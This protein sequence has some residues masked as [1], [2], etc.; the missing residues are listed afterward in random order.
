[1]AFVHL[2]VHT[3]YSIL[4]G[5]SSISTLF[6][7]AEEMGMPALAITDHGNMYGVKEFF[8]FAGK[9]VDKATGHF[10]VKPIIG[11]EVYVTRHYDPKLKDSE[12]RSYYHLILL[13]K[14][15]DGYKNLMKI[16]SQGHIEGLYYGKPRVSHEIIEK[17]HENLICCSACLAGEIPKNIVSGKMDEARKAIEWHKRVFGDDYYLE[18]MLH[19]TEV[20]G[21]SRDVY[22][23]QKISNEGIFQLA[24]EMGVK[25][26]ATND[27]HFVN[28]EDGPAHD[29]L[30]CLNTGKKINEEPR[31]H[32]TQQEYLKSE[33]EMAALFPDHPEVLENTLEI[34]SKV[35]EYQI[36]RDHVL[37]KY[38][39]DQ[40]FLDDLDNYLNM[41]KD[42]IEVGKCDKKGNYRGDEFC[43]SVAYLCHITYEGAKRRYG[44]TLTAEQSERIDFELKT[45]CRMGFPD[46]FLI[47]QDYIAASRAKGSMV[48][49]GRGS[50]AGSVVAYCLGITNLD[51]IKYQLLFERFLNPDRISMPDIDVDFEDLSLAH[52]Y[53]EDSY[54]KD[55][56]SRV[57]TFGT[58]LAKGAIKDVARIHDL[59]IDESN[60]L[61]G[62]VPDRLSEKVEKEYLFNPDL[63]DLKPG[64]KVVEKDVEVDDP[65][66]P[67]QKKTVKKTYQRGMEDTDVKITLKNC[68]RLVPEF[69]EELENGTEQ[70]REVLKY[71]RQLEGCIRQVGMHACAT[72]IGRGN[73][74]DYIPICLSMDKESGQYVWTSQYD[75][76]YIEE[77]GMLKMDF[78][79]LNTLSII[80]KCLDNIKLRFG[81]DIDIEAIPIDDKP[82]YELYGHGDTDSVFQFESEGMK[83]WLQRLHPER[84]EDLIAMNALYRPGPM[85]YIPDF[86]DR[87][88]GLKPIEY[89][90]P[91]MEEFLKDTYGVTVYQEQ[92]MLL[93]QKLAGFTK[94]QADKLRKAMGKK[95][96]TILN[97]LKDKFM[98]GGKANGHPEKIL[99]K[100]W[101]DWEKF[102]QYAFNKSHATCYAWVSYQTGWLK[103]HYPAEFFAANLSCNL[104]NMPE[105]KKILSDCKAHKI[106]VLNPDVNESYSH[107]TVNK[108]GNIRFGL[109][110]I[111]GFGSN[112]ADAII[113]DRAANGTY[114]DVFDFVERLGNSL[115]RKAIECLAYSGGFGSFGIQRKQF[116]LPC[117]SG[118]L[119]I[120]ELA[121]Y[122]T[123]YCQDAADSAASLFGE[124]EEMRPVRPEI[125]EMLGAD[126][127]FEWLQKEKEYV[128]MYISSHPLD[129]YAFEIE[130]FTNCEL[131]NLSK[132]V[133]ECEASRKKMKVAIAGLV[134]EYS[135]LTTKTGKPYSKTKLEDY[136]GAYELALFG[137]DHEAFMSYMKPHENLY[138]EGDIEEKFFIKPEERAQGKTSPYAFRVKKIMLLGN[139][140]E[141]ML[142][143]FS[144][145][146]TTPMLT[147]RFR[148]DLVSLIQSNRGT[149]PLKMYL[150]DPQTKYSIEFRSTKYKVAV[151]TDLVS[152][153]KLLGVQCAPVRK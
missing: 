86:V 127:E 95:Q 52:K 26:V 17:Y 14:N 110:G 64:F 15:F 11:C 138:I 44:E 7:R 22:E 70:V 20:P 141:T 65:D 57:I 31:L 38:Q 47:V 131:A 111:K 93:S 30:I 151:T 43:K 76:H 35:E 6:D 82:T 59:S 53:V 101:K 55:H 142:N 62:M 105:I 78:L 84:F 112:V 107:F 54:G 108:E 48:G 68:Y 75:G 98:E 5:F 25:V 114:A 3:Q 9:H 73:L 144:I 51:P 41:Y 77:V 34:A 85:D 129:K 120:D 148:K 132:Q 60:R 118:N 69:K 139:V 96:I 119:F 58:M 116:F 100:I 63:D 1:M 74:T 80:H 12:H 42:V 109:K 122:A 152:A 36:D 49:P 153:L 28:K 18:V 89:D 149:V 102:A 104:S 23:E 40:A 123:L 71:A 90:L 128:G 150:Y 143:A 4:D 125:P 146:I 130:N 147:E 99:D 124:A 33:E 32:Y 19:K 66:N 2:H 134:T 136:S 106:K 140:N 126:D 113:A 135:T 16:V 117:R 45:I 24:Q 61:S 56:V 27:V 97:E 39:I 133:A 103:C 88:L 29:H 91:E 81:T 21:L 94:G 13:A 137:R 46:Y 50:A 79:G 67:G 72:I 37:P 87:K 10:K 8:K 92:V 115:G 83:T 145:S 121:R